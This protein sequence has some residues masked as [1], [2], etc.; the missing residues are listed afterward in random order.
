[1][2]DYWWDNVKLKS[3][4]KEFIVAWDEAEDDS[5]YTPDEAKH[6]TVYR[7]IQELRKMVSEGT[8]R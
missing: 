3:T 6:D 2:T 5:A 1:M 7:L 8:E 4:V